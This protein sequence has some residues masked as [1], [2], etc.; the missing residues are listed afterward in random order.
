ML[1]RDVLTAIEEVRSALSSSHAGSTIRKASDDTEESARDDVFHAIS[2]FKVHRSNFSP[3]AESLLQALDLTFLGEASF[4][5]IL[6]ADDKRISENRAQKVD[7]AYEALGQLEEFL[8]YDDVRSNFGFSEDRLCRIVLLDD[9]DEGTRVER[10]RDTIEGIRQIYQACAAISGTPK[11]D[12]RLL[13][14]DSGSNKSFDFLGV[15]E[16][17]NSLN[18]LLTSFWD[19]VLFLDAHKASARAKAIDDTLPVLREIAEMRDNENLSEREAEKLRQTAMNGI[20][21][22]GDSGAVTEMIRSND[23]RDTKSISSDRRKLLEDSTSGN[24]EEE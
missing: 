6:L 13:S 7:S 18:D 19:R 8:E 10:V 4:W 20:E 3:A 24:T 2:T 21:M 11:E 15:A 1:R 22:I 23:D 9:S 17:M 14:L 5:D 12:I 16:A